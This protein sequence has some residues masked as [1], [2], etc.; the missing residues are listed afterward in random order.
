[1]LDAL[2]VHGAQQTPSIYTIWYIK[3]ESVSII[4]GWGNIHKNVRSNTIF[5]KGTLFEIKG[6]FPKYCFALK[7]PHRRLKW[8]IFVSNDSTKLI[9]SDIIER[10]MWRKLGRH[11]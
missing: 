1:M 9:L 7:I 4:V 2:K 6:K 8:D 10:P 5:L 11:T 3:Y